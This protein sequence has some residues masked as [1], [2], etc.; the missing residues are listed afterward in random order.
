MLRLSATV[1]VRGEKG[2][3][4]WEWATVRPGACQCWADLS[5]MLRR[6]RFLVPG[7]AEPNRLVTGLYCDLEWLCGEEAK[8]AVSHYQI[9]VLLDLNEPKMVAECLPGDELPI[10]LGTYPPSPHLKNGEPRK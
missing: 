9:R 2:W 4:Q 7:D 1:L 3:S 6:F 10:P 5:T 8:L